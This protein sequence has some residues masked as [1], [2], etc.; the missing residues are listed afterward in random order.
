MSAK[1][2]I[3][4]Y[5]KAL[6]RALNPYLKDIYFPTGPVF[7][8]MAQLA[9]DYHA[10]DDDI[11]NIIVPAFR[12]LGLVDI[13]VEEDDYLE[14][15]ASEEEVHAALIASLERS[16]QDAEMIYFMGA[17][18]FSKAH[19]DIF[20]KLANIV[21]FSD[22]SL[23][24]GI[25]TV[26]RTSYLLRYA[27]QSYYIKRHPQEAER[28]RGWVDEETMD[29]VG[30][31]LKDGYVPG[32]VYEDVLRDLV[33]DVGSYP[34]S[35]NILDL[36]L[37][38]MN[39]KLLF[40]GKEYWLPVGSDD[41]AIIAKLRALLPLFEVDLE[42]C[43]T[44]GLQILE[45][46]VQE[47]ARNITFFGC[48]QT[49]TPYEAELHCAELL[50]RLIQEEHARNHPDERV[51]RDVV[52]HEMALALRAYAKD[53]FVPSFVLLKE[54]NRL[55]EITHNTADVT[56]IREGTMAS[57][58]LQTAILDEQ[59]YL[60]PGAS[61]ETICRK[62][63]SIVQNWDLDSIY[64]TSN[65]PDKHTAMHNQ[66]VAMIF[67][68]DND[69]HDISGANAMFWDILL[70]VIGNH[71]SAKG[72]GAP[73]QVLTEIET[74][75]L[76]WQKNGLLPS[77]L[78]QAAIDALSSHVRQ[79]WFADHLYSDILERHDIEEIEVD[80]PDYLPPEEASRL[81]EHIQALIAA[82]GFDL[83]YFAQNSMLREADESRLKLLANVVYFADSACA[84][85]QDALIRARQILFTHVQSTHRTHFRRTR[86]L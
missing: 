25:Q 72:E 81:N 64:E 62:V 85:Q 21:F 58:S 45:R 31:F 36:S 33:A 48:A 20:T 19:E 79:P 35:Q 18:Q 37:D 9:S 47:I 75:C 32:W 11:S 29:I 14:P 55:M 6:E 22:E 83:E 23:P 86:R 84:S 13:D 16:G 2:D 57:L 50:S 15:G 40:L 53:G 70:P 1:F 69:I 65:I 51:T 39:A 7:A 73:A 68:A 26:A 71:L 3:H 67:F 74:V 8:I 28:C 63:Y 46:D 82:Y 30:P 17:D 49:T 60:L 80:G 10:D 61:V 27:L 12:Q 77:F 43:F 54:C 59:H 4:A 42:R 76:Q 24:I 66:L 41:D 78:R 56:A 44:E 5:M 52:D 34:L 38:A